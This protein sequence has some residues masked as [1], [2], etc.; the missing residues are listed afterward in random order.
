MAIAMGSM[1]VHM[2]KILL[3]ISG[4]IAAYKTAELV[5]RLRDHGAE[6]RV[7]M[8]HSAQAFI[9]P[10]ALQAVS[11]NQVHTS[12]LDETAEAA[13]GHIELARWADLVLIAPATA[14]T[15]AR[16]AYGFADDLLTTLCLA[17][18]A[19]I[20]VAPAMNQ[21]MW[22]A[23]ATAANVQRLVDYGFQVWGPEAGSQACGEVG[24]GRMLDPHELVARALNLPSAG[25][26][27]G[28]RV[29]ITAGPTREAIDPVRYISNHSSGKMG[30]A[31]ARAV[32]QA[33]GE[34]ILVS[35]PTA[36]AAPSGVE[37][38]E[39]E[40]AAQM[41]AA[42]MGV[43]G[44]ADVFVG[45]AAVADYA[46]ANL[47]TLK[48][49]KIDTDLSLE[50]SRNPDILADV[51]KRDTDLF[52]VGF[53]AETDDLER[54]ARGKLARKKL[55]MIA[56]NEVGDGRGF[57]VDHN[58]LSVYWHDGQ[59]TLGPADKQDVANALVQLIVAR[60]TARGALAS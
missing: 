54:N 20:A 4:G 49:K 10:L 3:G 53:A 60:L 26:L 48:I 19:P 57:D 52:T 44:D 45:A 58:T 39:V 43:I 14:H 6:V 29:V 28:R 16:L 47:A 1:T 55:D 5:R 59:Q 12:L 51:A 17:T 56:A 18:T 40:S 34:V 46:P 25:P 36:L 32:R 41:H 7:V 23:P 31:V 15:I 9:T 50:L 21:Q 13:M 38:I 11:G 33:G 30:Y 27:Q 8:T 42:V 2:M 35:G 24:P 22:Q 37:R